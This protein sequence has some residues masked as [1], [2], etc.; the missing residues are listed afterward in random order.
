M[1]LQGG[2]KRERKLNRK[3]GGPTFRRAR[4]GEKVNDFLLSLQAALPFEGA[5]V[6]CRDLDKQKTNRAAL[7]VSGSR[8]KSGEVFRGNETLPGGKRAEFCW[9]A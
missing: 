1:G 9:F 4:H 5:A 8:R 6:C 7:S 3:E 2:E